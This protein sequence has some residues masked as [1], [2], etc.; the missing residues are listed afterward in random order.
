M[1]SVALKIEDMECKMIS[2]M[3]GFERLEGVVINCV[4][5]LETLETKFDSFLRNYGVYSHGAQ[6]EQM[7]FDSLA[8]SFKPRG[9]S[10]ASGRSQAA[11]RSNLTNKMQQEKME[12]LKKVAQN[13]FYYERSVKEE[14]SFPYD[15]KLRHLNV[16]KV[17]TLKYSKI[18]PDCLTGLSLLMSNYNVVSLY[19][20]FANSKDLTALHFPKNFDT[21]KVIY[22]NSMFCGCKNLLSLDLSTFDT[23]KV[24]DMS[25]MFYDCSELE[26]LDLSSFDT[27]NVYCMESMF[28]G[29]SSLTKL[30]LSM[31]NTFRVINMVGMFQNCSSLEKLDLS[32]FRTG[33]LEYMRRMFKGCESLISLDLS[34]FDSKVVRDMKKLFE[35][36]YGLRDISYNAAATRL[37]EVI[38]RFATGGS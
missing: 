4:H 14:R 26:E 5:R 34:S 12:V 28:E 36:C 7:D 25:R 31:F 21:S 32:S 6:N 9:N 11:N 29:C 20:C 3:K 13:T 10:V 38:R 18:P 24:E 2:M 30:D 17:V 16:F 1:M 19:E 27:R 22:M 15:I 8:Q 37:G 35:G 23:S 33:R